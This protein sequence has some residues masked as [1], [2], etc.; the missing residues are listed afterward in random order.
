MMLC[1]CCQGQGGEEGGCQ[2]HMHT[3]LCGDVSSMQQ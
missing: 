1:T 2:G 3:V